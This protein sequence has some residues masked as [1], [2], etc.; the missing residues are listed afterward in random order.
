VIKE[1]FILNKEKK[2]M[3]KCK[4]CGKELRI[5]DDPVG[6]TLGFVCANP[7]CSECGVIV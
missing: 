7:N 4:N 1:N 3:T 5:A 6:E 2:K